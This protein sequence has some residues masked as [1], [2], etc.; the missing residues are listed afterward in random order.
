MANITMEQ[1]YNTYGKSMYKIAFSIL[2]D[3][4]QAEDAVQNSLIKLVNYLPRIEDLYNNQ[5]KNLIIIT[6]KNVAIDKYR[7]NKKENEI[8]TVGLPDNEYEFA[9]DD[10]IESV[11]EQEFLLSVFK[12]LKPSQREII[13]MKCFY[14]LDYKEISK[15][16]KIKESTVRKRYSRAK[17]MVEEIL[18]GVCDEECGENNVF[19]RKA[20]ST[21]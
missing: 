3:H 18:G 1:L 14:G 8:I 10:C 16:L 5:T 7:R 13:M 17:A 11:I 12:K 19:A 21:K 6:I 20:T 15:I 9:S 4:Q 2:N